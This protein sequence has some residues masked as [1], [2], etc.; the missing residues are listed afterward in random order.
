[1]IDPARSVDARS[2]LSPRELTV[3]ALTAEGYTNTRAAAELGVSVHAVKFHLASIYRKL[4]V[5][6]RTEAA[7]VF[8]RQGISSG[9]QTNGGSA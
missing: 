1:M 7:A 9:T 8:L 5:R 2:V 6:N 4:G 3:L